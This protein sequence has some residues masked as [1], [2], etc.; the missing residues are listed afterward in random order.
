MTTDRIDK[1]AGFVCPSRL[2]RGP[3]GRALCRWCGEEIPNNG[4]RTFC[5]P[6]C[7]EQHRI[8][9]DPGHVR[10]LVFK[11]DHGVCAECGLDTEA[12]RLS[13]VAVPASNHFNEQQHI[14]TEILTA[15]GWSFRQASSS[16]PHHLSRAHKIDKLKSLWQA[17][18]IKPVV[19]GG[20]S[21]GLDNYRTLCVPCHTKATAELAARRAQAR[22]KQLTITFEVDT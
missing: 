17:D 1:R 20:G 10:R 16:L 12:L 4:R 13:V 2:P 5:G 22:K 7:V 8:L 21:C 11:R 3:N 6:E 18:H 15:A 9:T 14:R 19:E